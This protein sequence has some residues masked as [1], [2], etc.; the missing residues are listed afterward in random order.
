[1]HDSFV[2][3]N[4][5]LGRNMFVVVLSGL[6]LGFLL[7][8]PDSTMIRQL[9]ILLFAYMT[10]V[11]ALGT[12]FKSFV[13][14]LRHPW[15]PLWVLILVHFITP[16][17]AWLAGIIFYP[18]QPTIRI[19][20][21][22]GASI[23]IGVTS[24]IWT[25]LVKGNMAVSLVA[26]TLDTFVV[27]LVLPLFFKLFI[28]QTIQLNYLEM[29]IELSLMVTLPSVVGMLLHDLTQGK[30]VSF[31]KSIGGATSKLSL[32]FVILINASLVAPQI[33]WDLAMVKILLVTLLIVSAGYFVG[34]LGS[35]ILKERTRETVLTMIY[36]VGIRNNACGLVL[37]LSYFPP[38]AAIP[39]T[40]SI[41]YQQPLATI[42][43]HLYKQFEKKQQITN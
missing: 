43:P 10:F 5:W 37:A 22:I 6:I 36:N 29:I 1:M 32:L 26:V 7:K 21:L 9:V 33:V 27:P 11:T 39:I 18:D 13:K 30:V 12:S 19:G 16:L 17:T 15:I 20:Y 2:K 41:L 35:L 25:A 8:L 28:G 40:L 4:D 34:F 24:I 23:P 31:S 42:I 3:L 14:V 38:A